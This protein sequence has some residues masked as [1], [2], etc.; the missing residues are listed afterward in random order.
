MSQARFYSSIAATTTLEASIDENADS[1]TPATTSGFPNSYPYLLILEKDTANEELVDVTGS[2]GLQ[3]NVIRGVDGTSPR[4]HSA[5]SPVEHGVSARDF[6]ESR[7]HEGS[8]DTVHG[9]ELGSEVV[10][11]TDT[12][13]LTNKTIVGAN[14]QN[15]IIDGD[16]SLEGN[17]DMKGYQINNLA[18]PTQAQDAATKSWV[19]STAQDITA[20]DAALARDWAIK[21][22]GLVNGEDYSS[23]YYAGQSSTSATAS[24]NSASAS[25]D[26]AA[27]SAASALEAMGYAS[28]AAEIWKDF[29]ARYLGG[30]PS[31][32][33]VDGAGEQLQSGA[34]YYNTVEQN[35]F[36]YDGEVWIAASSASVQTLATFEFL[37]TD[38][39][40]DFSG[41]DENGVL[42]QFSPGNN[43]VFLNGV[44]LSPGEDFTETAGV[45]TLAA[46]AAAGDLLNVV[47]FTG[48]V[49]ANHYTKSES[50]AR[51]ATKAE[52][53]TAGFNP[54]FLIGA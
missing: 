31:P 43:Q 1:L 18:D 37:A 20:G 9:L 35:M 29:E 16:S 27:E 10:G 15:P 44:M 5:G 49:V 28:N 22:D 25:A 6:R 39:Q 54:F 42:M 53:D 3:L 51:Y 40:T 41:V 36:V 4:A 17:L 48:F 23:K 32:P 24:A 38:G 52:L 46:P 8:A 14:I 13:T 26:S 30:H 34:L 19:E 21:M 12:Q 33:T 2:T 50:D 11:T 47:A 7:Q 45:V